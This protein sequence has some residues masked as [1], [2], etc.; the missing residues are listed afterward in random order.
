M[1]FRTALFLIV[2]LLSGLERAAAAEKLVFATGGFRPVAY[3]E[4]ELPNGALCDILTE[5]GRRAGIP[6]E[7][8]F[9]P[10]A[11]SMAETQAGRVDAI[12]PIFRTPERET[13]FAF[14]SEILLTETIS[15]FARADSP[16]KASPDLTDTNGVRVGMVS[17]TSFGAKFDR[18]VRDKLLS[19]VET[20]HSV[21]GAVKLLAAGRVDVVPCFNEAFWAEARDLGIEGRFK[22][23]MPPLDALPAYLAFSRT[24]D[25]GAEMQALDK[26]LRAMKDDGSYARILAAHFHQTGTAS[27]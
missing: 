19:D 4:N 1:I 5:A 20:V 22:E 18:A 17:R 15:W 24:R 12:F 16:L 21:T 25:H 13:L 23:L 6:I 11:R 26:A 10:W 14:P 3:V 2:F 7:F 27:R 8:R 9:L